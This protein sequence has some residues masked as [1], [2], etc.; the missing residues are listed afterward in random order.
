VAESQRPAASRPESP[1]VLAVYGTLRRGERNE[2]FLD[3]AT[4]LG[5]G[6]IGGRLH[7]M[8]RSDLR[9]YAYPALV[10][11]PDG[12]VP[13][14]LYALADAPMLAAIDELETFDPAN[15]AGSQYVRR[16]VPVEGG[17][18]ARAWVYVYNGPM[19]EVGERIA[20]GDW[21]AHAERVGTEAPTD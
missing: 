13:V 7:E 8:P 16:A 14:E 20:N 9:A 6:L 10:A 3:G 2:G 5:R 19:D 21:V 12:R 18:I 11:D 4:F 1:I 15:V 17:P